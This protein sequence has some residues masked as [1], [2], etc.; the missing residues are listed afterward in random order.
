MTT[1]IFKS[2]QA[3]VGE[4]RKRKAGKFV[5]ESPGHWRMLKEIV[6]TKLDGASV[7]ANTDEAK[8]MHSAAR[9]L[10]KHMLSKKG[11][12]NRSVADKFLNSEFGHLE[13]RRFA[14]WKRLTIDS[15]EK[16]IKHLSALQTG[17]P[18]RNQTKAFDDVKQWREDLEHETSSLKTDVER[19][20]WVAS[21]FAAKKKPIAHL[22]YA[23]RE[24]IG[25]ETH[26]S[27]VPE[28]GFKGLCKSIIQKAYEHGPTE[29]DAKM[30]D[31]F[32]KAFK[33]FFDKAGSKS[34]NL[35]PL[36]K[37]LAKGASV[38]EF[39]KNPKWF[40]YCCQRQAMFNEGMVDLD[41]I[42]QYMKNAMRVHGTKNPPSP[43]YD[44]PSGAMRAQAKMGLITPAKAI[45]K[46]KKEAK[47]SHFEGVKKIFL[48]MKR[49]KK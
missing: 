32:N 34:D 12:F 44:D 47:P 14:E 27:M 42:A 40:V 30:L 31:R 20:A 36:S 6:G 35:V 25:R 29:F 26:M 2:K 3:L 1:F 4:I 45:Q 46:M 23:A 37:A 33:T 8:K 17:E 9:L 16:Y 18:V 13:Y 10:T 28:N 5:K 15:V 41:G 48:K 38:P 22:L 7:H 19:D 43:D 49:N 24:I 21:K 39:A 11:P